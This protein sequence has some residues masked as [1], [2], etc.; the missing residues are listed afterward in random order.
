MAAKKATDEAAVQTETQKDETESVYSVEELAESSI[1]VFGLKV[2]SE[3]VVAAFKSI[4]K[5]SAT[6]NEAKEIVATFM[7]KEVK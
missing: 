3:C 4:G 7:K 6:V 5:D 1:K 2:R